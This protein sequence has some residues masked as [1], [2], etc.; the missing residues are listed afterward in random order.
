MAEHA[1]AFGVEFIKD[2]I[3]GMD[4]PDKKISGKK[5]DYYGKAII[6]ALGA[7]PRLL[8]VAGEGKLRGK[9]VSY[10]ATCDADL[11]EE[12]DVAVVGSGDAAI[13]EAE[14]LTRFAES[15]TM[16]VIHEEGHVDANPVSAERAFKS[17][18]IEWIWNST[19]QKING[20]E[21]VESITLKNIKTGEESDLPVNG[22]FIY[23]GTVPKTDLVKDVLELNPQGYIITDEKMA[24][25]IEGVF[26]AGDVRDKYLRQVVTA[27]ADGSIAAVA[28]QRYIQ[29][30]EL[31]EKEV[32]N[33]TKPVVVVYYDPTDMKG[34]EEAGLVDQFLNEN[35]GKFNLVKV[36]ATRNELVKNRYQI[37]EE[38]LPLVQL[39][40]DGKVDT[41]LN[42]ISKTSLRGLLK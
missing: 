42:T 2:T 37:K 34:T 11:F 27:V 29:D 38:D 24:T 6:F 19:V 4:L 22:V 20:D 14:Y 32:M 35:P 26:A 23:I 15:V 9:G 33:S 30:R 41:T 28:A 1:E 18:K 8:S 10:C 5:G 31:W 40:V 7:E 12:L 17:P 21:I 13:E 3:I 39:F 16:V 25:N 36:D